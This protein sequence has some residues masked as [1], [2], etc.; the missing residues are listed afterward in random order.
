[1]PDL[2]DPNLSEAGAIFGVSCFLLTWVMLGQGDNLVLAT[3]YGGLISLCFT[4]G[5]CVRA[6]RRGVLQG[7]PFWPHAPARD[8]AEICG[9]HAISRPVDADVWFAQ[10]L[11]GLSAC[12]LSLAILLP[13][14]G[15]A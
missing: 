13:L 6:V 10:A 1:M 3:K 12:L 4:F 7:L 15:L 2:E 5:F 11:S 14:F 9:S 8:G